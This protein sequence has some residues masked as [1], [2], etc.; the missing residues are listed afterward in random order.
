M[1]IHHMSLIRSRAA[2]M[3]KNVLAGLAGLA[4]VCTSSG[5]VPKPAKTFIDYFLPTPVVGALT[6]NIWGA[7]A[8]G[9]RDPQNG[10]EDVTMKQWD[11]WDGKIIKGPD[12]RYHLFCSRWE[13]ARGHN[14]WFQSKTVHAVSDRLT[15]PYV[16]KGLCWPDSEGGKGHN[17][18]ALQLAD[19]RYAIVISETRPGAV[20]VSKSLDGPWERGHPAAHDAGDAGVRCRGGA[21]GV[22]GRQRVVEVGPGQHHEGVRHR[23][24]RVVAGSSGGI[25]RADLVVPA[26]LRRDRRCLYLSLIHI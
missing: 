22:H 9:P 12:G 14:G 11:Y 7:A 19:G 3:L 23:D 24:H 25:R 17:V 16:D 20:Y 6:T 10:L 2:K 18:T 15:G 8:V 21:R 1:S 4:L 5:Q 26:V 13:Q